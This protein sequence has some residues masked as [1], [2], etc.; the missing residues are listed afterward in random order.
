MSDFAKKK[1]SVPSLHFPEQDLARNSRRRSLSLPS[2]IVPEETYTEP[3][4]EPRELHKE[5]RSAKSDNC[6]NQ[7]KN[8]QNDDIRATRDSLKTLK[9]SSQSFKGVKTLR[10]PSVDK[11]KKK[12]EDRRSSANKKEK[13]KEKSP[14][15]SPGSS[16]PRKRDTSARR[17]RH[18]RE[19]KSD[20]SEGERNEKSESN[21]NPLEADD[22]SDT[23]VL[24]VISSSISPSYSPD[25]TKGEKETLSSEPP[26]PPPTLEYDSSHIPKN[27]QK[28]GF[29]STESKKSLK[30]SG[31]EG[32]L[33][34]NSTPR[35]GTLK[36]YKSWRLSH[37][38]VFVPPTKVDCYKQAFEVGPNELHSCY[39]NR[40][41]TLLGQA[42]FDYSSIPLGKNTEHL[43]WMQNTSTKDPEIVG[44]SGK[45]ALS[46]LLDIRQSRRWRRIFLFSYQCFIDRAGLLQFLE[47]YWSI[48]ENVKRNIAD[49]IH[50]L[51]CDWVHI[52]PHDFLDAKFQETFLNFW[53]TSIRPHIF[54]G[55][56]SEDNE[57]E[58]GVILRQ[59]LAAIQSLSEKP[60]DGEHG[61]PPRP[62]LSKAMSDLIES[63]VTW[64]LGSFNVMDI[65][66]REI[67]RQMTLIDHHLFAQV[68][69]TEF[70]MGAYSKPP[71]SPLLA[72]WSARFNQ[73]TEWIGTTITTNSNLKERRSVVSFFISVAVKLLALRNFQGLMAVYLGLTQYSVTRMHATW[74]GLSPSI[75]EKWNKL[76]SICSPSS[77]FKNLRNLQNR[78]ELP[79]VKAAS[80]LIRDMTV[81]EDG[82]PRH[83]AIEEIPS[84]AVSEEN[85]R[86][87]HDPPRNNFK[88]FNVHRIQQAGELL[89]S[90][91]VAQ[92]VKYELKPVPA[93]QTILLSVS[94]LCSNEQEA[95]SFKNEPKQ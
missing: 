32:S 12:D 62:I 4:D 85:P 38:A 66:P 70:Q 67:A 31:L 83:V 57:E 78:C 25:K 24:E 74:T 39:W 71:L 94:F 16:S 6:D 7:E 2:M 81:I 82:N 58:I 42:G 1:S 30:K 15:F 72:S 55:K 56:E 69:I 54:T 93:I 92:A 47:D 11:K 77:N 8:V 41:V 59:R 37:V 40:L 48:Q 20:R 29:T 73:V 10:S 49:N 5:R 87:T 26:T 9:N 68:P 44:I 18:D 79:C 91:Q 95:A 60:Y 19:G 14:T 86:A 52:R 61:K 35:G 23:E 45:M 63:N 17:L 43:Y 28:Y 36:K 22:D 88:Y 33:S 50:T 90:I 13:R 21:D 51:L 84:P 27:M 3:T 89:E 64:I 75:Q 53:M 46:L 65:H 76:E 34:A 80:L